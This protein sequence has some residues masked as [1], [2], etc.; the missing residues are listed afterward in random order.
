MWLTAGLCLLLL[1]PL[2]AQQSSRVTL[3]PNET[4]FS[5]LAVMNACGY[6]HEL[7]VSDALRTDIRNHVARAVA[8]S[9]KAAATHREI[10][11]FYRDHQQV[12]QVRDLSQYIS[13][14]LNLGGPPQFLPIV[15]ESDLPP[16]AG[17]VLGLQPLLERY[18]ADAGLGKIW[19]KNRPA[20]ERHIDQL[21]APVAK[22]LLE[23]DVY[24][25]MPFSGGSGLRF[26]VYVEPQ[27]APGQV[28]ARNYGADYFLV[29]SPSANGLRLEEVR[30][31]YLHH[32]LD[33]L[34]QRRASAFK[35][36]EPLLLAVKAAPLQE[37]YKHDIAL[38]TNESLIRAIEARL[39]PPEGPGKKA[40]EAVEKVRKADAEA[41]MKEGFILT[42]YFY[43][44]LKNFEDSPV[45]MRDA[46]PN[47]LRE[48]F[49][50]SERKRAEETEFGIEARPEVVRAAAPR[51]ALM[52]DLAEDRLSRGDPRA[53][54]R[55]AQ[56]ALDE[57]RE[58][59]ARALFILARSATLTG[60]MNGA[61]VY[62]ERSLGI[63]REPRMIA[64]SHIYLGR[65]FDLQENR[66]AALRHYR[67]ALAAGDTTPDTRAAAERG[68][69]QAY[70]PPAPR[71]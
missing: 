36:L 21:H 35:R 28:N 48:I 10:C 63:A 53:A 42:H 57:R 12:D 62:F 5:V 24:L 33:P 1:P 67:A 61:R 43:E 58:D 13:L 16:D 26:V 64:W 27:A 55:L 54:Q 8:E 29:V 50:D 18:Y 56:Q 3:E 15:K 9:Q 2:P 30:H 19:E 41:S 23:T 40:R 68:L 59:A 39:I 60:D 49:V 11:Q 52:L 65:I 47:L 20:Y 25:K 66:E 69:E 71:R 17:Y 38:L 51:Q 7:G 46:Y 31:T 22:M 44:A 32:V 14:A 6:N 70:T 4:L 34:T 37:G 45:G